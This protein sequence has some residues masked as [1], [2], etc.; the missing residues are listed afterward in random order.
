MPCMP[1]RAGDSRA[2]FDRLADR[3]PFLRALSCD[4]RAHLRPYAYVRT[5]ARAEPV[6][7]QQ[8]T[9]HDFFFLVEGH[10]KLCRPSEAGHDVIIDAYAAARFTDRQQGRSGRHCGGPDIDTNP[11]GQNFEAVTGAM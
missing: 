8:D 9:L 3:V 1:R 2:A 7:R 10:T 5:V 4:D 6:W 11:L